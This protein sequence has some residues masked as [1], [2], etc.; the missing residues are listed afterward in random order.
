[1]YNILDRLS[2][3]KTASSCIVQRARI[4]LLAYQGLLNTQISPIVELGRHAVGRWRRRWQESYDALLSI[5]LNEP[6]SVLIRAVTDVLRDAHRSGTTCK[7]SAQQV[8]EL[9]SIAC[10]SPR[11]SGRPV[12]DWTGAE[13]G[14]EMQKRKVVDSI[15]VSRVNELLR[16]VDLQPHRRKYWC[17]TTEKDHAL[18]QSQAES[19]CQA[20]LQAASA[21]QRDGRRTVC[22]DEMTSLQANELRAQTLRSIPGMIGRS[23][24]QYTRHGTLSLT[25]SWDVVL[26]QMLK[27]TIQPTRD[28]EDFA[29]HIEKTIATDPDAPWVFV[30]DNLNT[31]YGEPVVRL[32]AK[33]LGITEDSLGD[34]KKRKGVLGSVKSRREFLSNHEH[35][36]QFVFLPKHSSWLNQIEVIF[37]IISRRVMRHGSFTSKD[38]LKQKLTS[39][40]KY[41]NE[42]FAKPFNWTYNGKPTK[43]KDRQRPRTWRE[44]TQN[45][46]LKQI[47]ALVA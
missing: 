35:R 26:G 2:N 25:G 12:E 13:L 43:N 4:I 38:E 8:I 22:V 20:Y 24:C 34:K 16:L 10:E 6:K 18:F 42:T 39:F 14:D 32:V 47:L 37:G 41:F 17:F 45:K 19:V 44:K 1:M 9:V 29:R 27:N 31:H 5:Q 40:I 23:E 11:S 28:S 36:I 3:R 46:R 7:F 30:L 33:H 15:S 21:Y